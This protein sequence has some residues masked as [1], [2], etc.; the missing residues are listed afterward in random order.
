VHIGSVVSCVIHRVHA[1]GELDGSVLH[2]ATIKDAG[3]QVLLKVL[4]ELTL[5]SVIV[6]IAIVRVLHLYEQLD[7]CPLYGEEE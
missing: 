1:R 2:Q 5:V 4:E 7:G 6:L 3:G